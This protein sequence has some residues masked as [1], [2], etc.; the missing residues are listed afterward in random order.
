MMAVSADTDLT[1]LLRGL[2]KD[3]CLSTVDTGRHSVIYLPNLAIQ[4]L[5]AAFATNKNIVDESS[6]RTAVTEVTSE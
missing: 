6:I 4:A 3:Q 5:V 2:P 1:E